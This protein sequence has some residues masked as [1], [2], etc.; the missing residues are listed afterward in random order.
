MHSSDDNANAH[1]NHFTSLFFVFLFLPGTYTYF[2][3]HMQIR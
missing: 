2:V 3:T 1:T